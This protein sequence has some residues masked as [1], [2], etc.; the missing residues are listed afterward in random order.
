MQN[1]GNDGCRFLPRRRTR[2]QFLQAGGLGMLGLALPEFLWA[3]AAVAR[4][5]GSEKS[6][7]F[8]VQY[9]SAS[10]I[11]TIDPK[12]DAVDVIRGPYRPIASRV[13]GL[14]FSDML[15]RLASLADR[16]C[17]L[18]SMSHGHGDHEGGMHVCMTGK[19]QPQ[20]RS[21]C[22]GSVVARLQPGRGNLPSY[23]WLQNLDA[24]VRQWYLTSGFLPAVYSPL[25]IG[26]GAN[27][28]AAA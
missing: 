8:I 7:I 22:F 14:H 13:P 2:R 4:P 9:G 20:D 1:P 5:R 11:D 26:R 10:H 3:Q 17:V 12:P 6:C 23:V 18:H 27:N 21:P 24:D 19:S 28:P 16:Y 15:P 25:T